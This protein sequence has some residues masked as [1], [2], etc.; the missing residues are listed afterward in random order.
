M[1]AKEIS[2]ESS[3]DS[4][5]K[6]RT[7]HDRLFK[8]FIRLFF[9]EFLEVFLRRLYHQFKASRISFLDKELFPD[10]IEGPKNFVDVLA[11][12][13]VKGVSKKV[14]CHIEHQAQSDKEFNYRMGRYVCLLH[15]IHGKI[16]L[17]IAVYT[18][19]CKKKDDGVYDARSDGR[20]IL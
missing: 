3:I 9:F 4:K 8:E 18:Y 17:P 5:K 15:V 7:E 14:Q 12:V 20:G 6:A 19:E 11:E 10:I 1:S 2:V 16:V 13:E